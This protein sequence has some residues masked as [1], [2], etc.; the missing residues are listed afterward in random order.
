MN[1]DDDAVIVVFEKN[2]TT[3]NVWCKTLPDL[4]RQSIKKA[5]G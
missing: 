5:Q 3:N 1:D 2:Q 4:S